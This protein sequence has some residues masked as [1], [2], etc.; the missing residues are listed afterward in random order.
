ML[1]LVC[2]S[3]SVHYQG[4]IYE[5]SLYSGSRRSSA[6]AVRM[7]ELNVHE[8][9][10][11]LIYGFRSLTIKKCEFLKLIFDV[12]LSLLNKGFLFMML[13][14]SEYRVLQSGSGSKTPF[15]ST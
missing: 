15:I 5:D 9:I 6:R 2:V 8:I 11:L 1:F 7:I 4:S 12:G 14:Y 3:I 13:R 10:T